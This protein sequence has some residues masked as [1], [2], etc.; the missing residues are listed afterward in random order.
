MTARRDLAETVHAAELDIDRAFKPI[1]FALR[2][3]VQRH[4]S[5]P[6][7]D[8]ARRAILRDVDLFL[9]SLYG[10]KR[11]D[12]SPMARLIVARSNEARK[13][14]LDAEVERIERLLARRD[15][16]ELVER[17]KRA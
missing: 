2:R 15:E 8:A 10:R 11:G 7:T 9:D 3:S 13:K 14:P 17:M 5:G 4:A 12:D 6:V 16:S 1:A